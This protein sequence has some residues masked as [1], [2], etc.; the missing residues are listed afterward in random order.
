MEDKSGYSPE[1]HEI[2]ERKPL[3]IIRWGILVIT[4]LFLMGLAVSRFIPYAENISIPI[5]LKSGISST[6]SHIV[7]G[8][9]RVKGG[10]KNFVKAGQ[11]AVV[12]VVSD[13]SFRM[14]RM[15][16]YVVAIMPD[17]SQ[18]A[19]SV[20]ILIPESQV[21]WIPLSASELPATA[22]ITVG[23][24]DLLE[25]IFRPIRGMFSSSTKTL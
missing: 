25:Q 22:R 2:L 17:S 12:S 23:R 4:V 8:I 16:G 21:D 15:V 18:N 6:G 20:E 3:W 11:A 14:I 13:G 19:F 5:V 9:A 7:S 10:D 1:V 24:S